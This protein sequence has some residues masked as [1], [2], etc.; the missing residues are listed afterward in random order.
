MTMKTQNEGTLAAETP[1]ARFERLK[2]ELLS[3]T[4]AQR[5][6]LS[7]LLGADAASDTSQDGELNVGPPTVPLFYTALTTYLESA[8]PAY[9]APPLAIAARSTRG[10]L[11]RA[12]IAVDAVLGQHAPPGLHQPQRLACYH[13]VVRLVLAHMR[14]EAIPVTLRTVIQQCVNAALVLDDAFPGYA[15]ANLLRIVFSRALT[16]SSHAAS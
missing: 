14:E 4:P 11:A 13:F 3:I 8:I 10:E 9:R 1:R 5:R 2:G 15:K 6:T 7:A 16:T 12:V